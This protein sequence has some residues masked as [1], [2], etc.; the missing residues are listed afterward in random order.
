MDEMNEDV[1]YFIVELKEIIRDQ[2]QKGRGR[3]CPDGQPDQVFYDKAK[4]FTNRIIKNNRRQ[5]EEDGC[6]HGLQRKLT[7][8]NR[9]PLP[10]GCSVGVSAKYI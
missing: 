9:T 10:V 2:N 7:P 1:T 3:Y 6:S 5:I 8:G 4:D